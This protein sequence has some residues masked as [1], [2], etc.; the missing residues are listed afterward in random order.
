MANASTCSLVCALLLAGAPA[1]ASAQLATLVADLNS[2]PS[3]TAGSS[4]PRRF[5]DLGGRAVFFA[6]VDFYRAGVFASDGTAVGTDLLA[7]LC[8]LSGFLCPSVRRGDRYLYW[9][10]IAAGSTCERTARLFRTDGTRAG[11]V[12]LTDCEVSVSSS[13]VFHQGRLFFVASDLASGLVSVGVTDG[14]SEGTIFLDSG[15]GPT[16]AWSRLA[17]V[18]PH[19]MWLKPSGSAVEVLRSDGS[20]AGTQEIATLGSPPPGGRYFVSTGARAFALVRGAAGHEL[21][22]TDGT[23]PGTR[24]IGLPSGTTFE[25]TDRLEALGNRIVFRA[26]DPEHGRELY[27]SDGT[28]AGTRRVT[29]LPQVPGPGEPHRP[30]QARL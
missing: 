9:V 1:A 24:R 29:V 4:S 5:F 19:A 28:T 2:S 13:V 26:T 8:K 22:V 30:P 3:L 10:A 15:P 17:A 14:T 7:P 20:P 27:V 25:G 12:A 18:G 6:D 23:A 11:T 16:S 21:W